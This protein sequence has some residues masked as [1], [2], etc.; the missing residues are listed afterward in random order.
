MKSRWLIAILLLLFALGMRAEFEWTFLPIQ[1]DN[2]AQIAAARSF[3]DGKGFVEC[4]VKAAD[5]SQT[6]CEKQTWWAIGVPVLLAAVKPFVKDFVV[7]EFLLRVFAIAVL[8]VSVGLIYRLLAPE[9]SG[10]PLYFFLLFYA[11]LFPQYGLTFTSDVLAL[12]FFIAASCCSFYLIFAAPK[13]SQTVALAALCGF[14]L[15]ITGFSR[16]AYY[17]VIPIVPFAMLLVSFFRDSGRLRIAIA[18]M[19]ASAAGFFLLLETVLPGHLTAGNHF[20]DRPSGFFPEHLLLFDPFVFK[21]FLCWDLFAGFVA[22]F[23]GAI[24]FLLAAAIWL[25][26]AVLL[27]PFVA[28]SLRSFS[29]LW[30]EKELKPTDYLKILTVVALASSTLFLTLMSL[31]VAK[32]YEEDTWTFVSSTRYFLPFIVLFQINLFN[33]AWSL[34]RF[35]KFSLKLVIACFLIF[36]FA[37]N[38]G[39]WAVFR[40]KAYAGNASR[41]T[42]EFRVSTQNEINQLA[43]S[44]GEQERKPVVLVAHYGTEPLYE[45]R[46]YLSA[47]DF[48]MYADKIKASQPTILLIRLPKKLKQME[49]EFLEKHYGQ[50]I[51]ELPDSDLYRTEIGA[52]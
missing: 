50:K 26:S 43:D 27:A 2:G 5:V 33:Y 32:M 36:M 34:R 21:A 7:A 10:L 48:Y 28:S 49:T 52:N 35:R 20:K 16:Y 15:F 41:S 51:L 1:Y 44:I 40:F 6:V 37:V 24:S 22:N 23:G 47:I 25:V 39:L 8:L 4:A 29:G 19:L 17:S 3:L 12:A 46:K 9:V 31:R 45:K 30:F 18:A 42:H 13:L 14:F 11:F 38:V